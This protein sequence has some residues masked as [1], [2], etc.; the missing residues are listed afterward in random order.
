MDPLRTLE[1]LTMYLRASFEAQ[2]EAITYLGVSRHPGRAKLIYQLKMMVI[3][4][5]KLLDSVEK[6]TLE[7]IEFETEEILGASATTRAA[8]LDLKERLPSELGP[9]LEPLVELAKSGHKEFTAELAE[10]ESRATTDVTQRFAKMK[11]EIEG[12]LRRI[13][14]L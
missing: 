8:V 13:E 14:A 1:I 5:L 3:S 4:L 7:A 12:L 6:K 2:I 11:Q 10:S 9:M